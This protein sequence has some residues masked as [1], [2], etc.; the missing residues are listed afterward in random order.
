M[1]DQNHQHRA[2]IPLKEFLADYRSGTPD[3]DIMQRFGLDARRLVTLIKSLVDKKVLTAQDLTR[4]KELTQQQELVKQTQFLKSLFICPNCGHPHP[5]QFDVCPACGANPNEDVQVPP[6]EPADDVMTTGGHF[7][8]EDLT[9]GVHDPP[10]SE[11]VQASSPAEPAAEKLATAQPQPE[12]AAQP[13]VV[14]VAF[15]NPEAPSEE[16]TGETPE[17]ISP[18]KSVRALFSRIKKK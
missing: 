16:A 17:K 3:R 15:K 5:Q 7:Y 6:E 1:A 9:S 18:F 10:P 4:H 11:V 14:E 13:Q 2:K 12:P 8:V